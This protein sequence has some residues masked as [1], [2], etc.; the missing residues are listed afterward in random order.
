MNGGH[1]NE[2]EQE[3]AC[4]CNSAKKNIKTKIQ[5]QNFANFFSTNKL[6]TQVEY[7]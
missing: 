4:T 1:G 6:S 7:C 2:Q 3:I 5:A